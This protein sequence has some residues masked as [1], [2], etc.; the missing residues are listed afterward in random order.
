[1]RA[2]VLNAGAS[3]AAYQ[4][5]ALRHLVSER[6]LRFDLCAGTGIGAMHAAFVACGQLEMLEDLWA[7]IGLRRLVRPNWRQPWRDGPLVGTPQRRFIAAHVSE[8]RLAAEGISLAIS[9]VDLQGGRE[10]VL[11]YPGAELPLVDGLMAAVATPGLTPPLRHRGRQLVE[12]TVIDAVPMGAALADPA[13]EEIVA[14]LAAPIG[15]EAARRRY[16]TWRAVA[17]RALE[18]NQ[19]ADVRRA[20]DDAEGASAAAEAFR[21]VSRRVPQALAAKVDDGVLAERLRARLAEVYE[22]SE[23]PLRRPA[24]PRLVAITPSRDLRFAPWRFRAA[25]LDVAAALGHAD[26]QTVM[27]GA[28]LEALSRPDEGAQPTEGDRS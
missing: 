18:M 26:A 11:R 16:R 22:R 6:G 23:F 20:L 24:G 7:R 4:I 27:A 17:Q 1:M 14:V 19:A 3:W 12:A 9:V 28:E 2:L 13:V 5:G 21:A 15:A 25:E 10:Q 8:G